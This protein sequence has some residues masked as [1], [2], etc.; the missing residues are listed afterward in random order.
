MRGTCVKPNVGG[1]VGAGR[2]NR[3]LTLSPERDFESRASTS[4][5]IPALANRRVSIG[6]I[7][8]PARVERDDFGFPTIYIGNMCYSM[9][10]MVFN[11]LPTGV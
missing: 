10:A 3:T 7:L 8:A 4:S 9:E 5:A 1:V 6:I 2:E 11:L